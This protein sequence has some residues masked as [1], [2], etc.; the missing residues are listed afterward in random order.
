M[1][2]SLGVLMAITRVLLLMRL[3]LLLPVGKMTT[4]FQQL[5]GVVILPPAIVVW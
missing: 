2:L 4:T 3:M 1:L 5:A